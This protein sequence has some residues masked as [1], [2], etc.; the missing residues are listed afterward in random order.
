MLLMALQEPR[1]LSDITWD[2]NGFL[3][4]RGKKLSTTRLIKQLSSFEDK[5]TQRMAAIT[6]DL[7]AGR[8]TIVQWR[9]KIEDLVEESH[10]LVAAFLLGGIAIASKD[11]RILK[12][13]ADDKNYLHGFATALTTISYQ[14]KSRKPGEITEHIDSRKRK[15]PVRL[16]SLHLKKILNRL[17]SYTRSIAITFHN[18]W[19]DLHV[20]A[21]YTEAMRLRTAHESCR[22]V[23]RKGVTRIGCVEMSNRWMPINKMPRIGSLNCGLYCKCFIVFR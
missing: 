5:I 7:H 19:F 1:K 18:Y 4:I 3:L 20:K 11:K 22:T 13:A 14:D 2:S 10:V 9:E 12:R 15:I 8:I 21:G 23:T 17:R 16:K 6:R